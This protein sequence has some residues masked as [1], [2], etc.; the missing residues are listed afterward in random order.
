[1]K[2]SK[3]SPIIRLTGW[4]VQKKRLMK[5]MPAFLHFGGWI[6]LHVYSFLGIKVLL[7]TTVGRKTGKLRTVPTMVISDG[8]D[9][10]IAA[11][12]GGSARHP[13]WYFNLMANPRAT[14][15]RYWR[16]RPYRAEPITDPEER[17]FLLS[18]FPF[19]MV[20]ALQAHTAREIPLFRLYSQSPP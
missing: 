20:E 16:K 12:Y 6:V 18:Q 11:H 4:L 15:E 10:I 2:L 13:A 14:V 5:W 1:M 7:L 3:N 9:L 8:Q 17:R 19:D